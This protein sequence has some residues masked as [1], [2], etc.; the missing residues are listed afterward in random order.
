[1]TPLL[2][3]VMQHIVGQIKINFFCIYDILFRMYSPLCNFPFSQ[4]ASHSYEKAFTFAILCVCA[5]CTNSGGQSQSYG[6]EF[7]PAKAYLNHTTI[8]AALMDFCADLKPFI[9]CNSCNAAPRQVR[10]YSAHSP[11]P[12]CKAVS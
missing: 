4:I 7:Q 6:A 3:S 8:F 12:V 10:L 2:F 1:M 11:L 9:R 5:Q